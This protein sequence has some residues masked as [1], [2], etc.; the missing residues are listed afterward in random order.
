MTRRTSSSN[1]ILA[2]VVNSLFP[3]RRTLHTR[4]S[5]T[6]L[7]LTKKY[8]SFCTFT[9]TLQFAISPE[10]CCIMRREKRMEIL[11]IA[12]INLLDSFSQ[13]NRIESKNVSLSSLK[14]KKNDLEK[15]KIK[16]KREVQ[17]RD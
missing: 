15:E 4:E 2:L 8:P 9:A 14:I 11:F 10:K 3:L 13:Y 16:Y 5:G 1:C 7:P 12:R 17:V 6:E